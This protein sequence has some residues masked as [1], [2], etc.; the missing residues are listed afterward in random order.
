MN[1]IKERIKHCLDAH[2][3]ASHAVSPFLPTR[4]IYVGTSPDDIR[5]VETDRKLAASYVCLSHCWGK[6][7][8]LKTT[9][10]TLAANLASLSWSQ[11]PRTYQEAITVTRC[12]G[13]EYL[14]VDSLCIIQDDND[15]WA[16]ESAEMCNVYEHAY[17]T[18][19]ATAAKSAKDGLFMHAQRARFSMT[20]STP[21]QPF[22]VMALGACHHPSFLTHHILPPIWP[23]LQRAW[24]FQERFL[25]PRVVHFCDQEVLWECREQA[26]C[27]C[28]FMTNRSTLGK[29]G[30]NKVLNQQEP[31]R[32]QQ[33]WQEMVERYSPLS[34]SFGADKL[35]ALAG[36]ARQVSRKRPGARYLAGLWSDSMDA[37]L[38]WLSTHEDSGRPSMWRAPSWSWASIDGSVT[39]PLGMW[40]H[41]PLEERRNELVSSYYTLVEVTTSP[42]ALDEMGGIASASLTIEGIAFPAVLTRAVADESAEEPTERHWKL[43]ILEGED[44][45]ALVPTTCHDVPPLEQRSEQ[46]HAPKF[47]SKLRRA[48]LSLRERRGK[49]AAA[50]GDEDAR[51]LF[52]HPSQ[53]EDEHQLCLD[54]TQEPLFDR[55]LDTL[56]TTMEETVLCVRMGR[57][58]HMRSPPADSIMEMEYAMI[59]QH[60][61]DRSRYRR[62]G[63]ITQKRESKEPEDLADPA[64][65]W[66]A[67]PSC[68]EKGGKKITVTII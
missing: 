37:D 48:A 38:L 23:L 10:E 54:N 43:R 49:K 30:Y 36:L 52:L 41:S 55:A 66:R 45:L 46:Q 7:T 20:G 65:M 17:L 25:S 58:R 62:I 44:N 28:G 29:M 57:A 61:N 27:E 63:M 22:R 59:L 68:L 32:I 64:R 16:R 2:E 39:L 11:I 42:L 14:W 8:P 15:D 56:E 19:A 31:A 6:E 21:E 53:D 3:C 67:S 4:V 33:L 26:L 18:I 60:T 1:W 47:V 34:L 40:R 12:L 35:P 24:V 9:K 13:I 5:L 50:R 51:V